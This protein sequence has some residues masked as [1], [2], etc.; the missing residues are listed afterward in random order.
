M[1]GLVHSFWSKCEC[2]EF[3]SFWKKSQLLGLGIIGSFRGGNSIFCWP[4]ALLWCYLAGLFPWE[5]LNL[6]ILIF[7]LWPLVR[8]RLSFLAWKVKAYLPALREL[9]RRRKGGFSIWILVLA[10]YCLLFSTLPIFVLLSLFPCCRDWKPG[11][12]ISQNP[13]TAGFWFWSCQW[14]I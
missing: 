10:G 2:R 11:Y 5:I 14:E 13:L 7:F 12:Y 8:R 6:S 3:D 9:S 1:S 4:W